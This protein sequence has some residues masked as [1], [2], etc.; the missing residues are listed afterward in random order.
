[1]AP[2]SRARARQ[3][4]LPLR[5]PARGAQGRADRADEP[6]D[7]QGA[8]RG[9]RRRPGG[10]RHVVLHGRRGPAPVRPDDAVRAARQVPDVG[11]RCRSAS[12]A[13]SRRGTSRS[14][15]R[16]GSSRPRSS[17][18]T[19]SSSSRPR[20]RRCSP[21]ASSSCSSRRAC[22]TGVVNIVHGY[23]E[24][25][26]DRLVRHPDVPVITFTGSRET[27]V[28]RDEERRRLPQARPP[29]ARRQ[30][31]DHRHGRRRPRPRGRG[32][33][34][35][36]VR[37]LRPALHGRQPR[38][39]RTRRSTTSCRSASSRAPRRCARPRLGPDDGRR[40]GDQPG[41][42]RQDPLATRGIG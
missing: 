35:V 3:G 20:T 22:R 39:R 10:D 38:D 28:L 31:R 15:S 23:G 12:S 24:E 30:E 7:G 32:H 41:A 18:A 1:M 17:A 37:H 26:G 36:G 14:R 5:A 21:S 8:R 27:G 29:R 34:L 9:R 2:R 33:R 16:P 11:A 19:R 6:R 40:P 13:R 25:A 4:P 42:A